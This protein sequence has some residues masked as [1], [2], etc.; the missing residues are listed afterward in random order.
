[1]G[2]LSKTALFS[3]RYAGAVTD[4]TLICQV[5]GTE[6][7]R[8][9][10][11]FP[12]GKQAVP[13]PPPPSATPARTSTSA[14]IQVTQDD[15]KAL[16]EYLVAIFRQQA[17]SAPT[18]TFRDSIVDAIPALGALFGRRKAVV[19]GTTVTNTEA[20]NT[21][22]EA[23][24]QLRRILEVSATYAD[25]APWI[26]YLA[27]HRRPRFMEC[28]RISTASFADFGDKTLVDETSRFGDNL[29]ARAAS[30]MDAET[31]KNVAELIAFQKRQEW[32][33]AAISILGEIIRSPYR[34]LIQNRLKGQMFNLAGNYLPVSTVDNWAGRIISWCVYGGVALLVGGGVA[35]LTG[36]TDYNEPQKSFGKILASIGVLSLIAA[37]ALQPIDKK[38]RE[39]QAA[40]DRKSEAN[41][42]EEERIQSIW[43]E[44]NR[45]AEAF[46][47]T[48]K[49][50]LAEMQIPIT[51]DDM[52]GML[53]QLK[54]YEKWGREL[55]SYYTKT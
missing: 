46:E 44:V 49:P 24:F 8:M 36:E 28:Y 17:E 18:G 15:R 40:E 13:P 7:Q 5:G 47:T 52:E 48:V 39:E 25:K 31:A 19:A 41:T 23:L 1:M 43:N 50:L 27:A 38:L 45:L 29:G 42:K 3:M 26:P 6:W 22:R 2:S 21:K 54:A 34:E 35:F 37:F 53:E 12:S 9:G 10:D 32:L 55:E 20:E 14:A 16:Q 11:M 33:Q 51:I 4:E 30:L